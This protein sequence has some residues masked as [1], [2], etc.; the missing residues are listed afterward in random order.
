MNKKGQTLI[1]FVIIIPTLILLMAFVVDTGMVLKENTR[2]S[3]T[4][5]T[6]LRTMYE[7]KEDNNFEEKI[8]N[9]Y[10][11]NNIP[12]ENIK[13]TSRNNEISIEN[14]YEIESIFGRIIGMKVYP[15]KIK[16]VAS[17]NNDK[18]TINKE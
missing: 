13:I 14:N 9:L 5:K 2:L 6:I 18:I 11:K 10:Q 3:S 1:L 8:K 17:K 12:I 16:M 7:E 15:L 4:T